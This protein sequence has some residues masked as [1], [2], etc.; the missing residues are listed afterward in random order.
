MRGWKNRRASKHR[1]K[2]SHCHPRTF[3]E[4]LE[5]RVM[6]TGVTLIA[7][8]FGSDASGWVSAMGDAIVERAA[9]SIDFI[10]YTLTVTDPGHD[11]GEL[12]VAASSPQ[13]PALNST[14]AANPEIMLL[15]DWSDVAGGLP[16]GGYHRSTVDV[17]AAVAAKLVTP[18]FLDGLVGHEIVSL[19][20]HLIG[21]SRGGSLVNELARDLGKLGVWV[22]HLSTL[23]PHPVKGISQGDVTNWGDAAMGAPQ[24]VQFA[25]NYWRSD[26]DPLDF[27]GESVAG[28]HNL[29]LSESVLGSFSGYA[30]EHSDVHLW[31]HGTI[32]TRS[33]ARDD[34]NAVPLDWYEDAMGPRQKVG[35]QFSRIRG[36]ARPA[37]GIGI[38]YGGSAQ[39]DNVMVGSPASAWPSIGQVDAPFESSGAM[40]IGTTLDLDYRY[41]LAGG[42]GATVACFADTDRNPFDGNEIQLGSTQSLSVTGSNVSYRL[43]SRPTSS[44]IPGLKYLFLRV[45]A[46]GHTRYDYLPAPLTFANPQVPAPPSNSGFDRVRTL[47]ASGFDVQTFTLGPN[48]HYIIRVADDD[49]DQSSLFASVQ[50]FSPTGASLTGVG[51]G[52]GSWSREAS[53]GSGGTFRLVLSNLINYSLD[54]R[55]LLVRAPGAQS[56]DTDGDGGFLKSGQTR[57][58]TSPT[59]DVDVYRF[60]VSTPKTVVFWSGSTSLAHGAP[61]LSVFGP[62]GTSTGVSASTSSF[63]ASVPGT[64]YMLVDYAHADTSD[65]RPYSVGFQFLPD[66]LS[67]SADGDR[68]TLS[69]GE[70]RTLNLSAEE[71]AV[72]TFAA[73]QN[74]V[75]TVVATGTFVYLDVF[76][77]NGVSLSPT[78]FGLF[79]QADITATAYQS[80]IY[81]VVLRRD[82][83]AAS[84][85]YTVSLSGT[86][87]ALP[88]PTIDY[89][90]EDTGANSSD[91]VTSDNRLLV[92]GSAAPLSTVTLFMQDD[93]VLGTSW[94]GSDGHWVFDYGAVPLP[95]GIAVIGATSF[96]AGTNTASVPSGVRTVTVDTA[97][98]AVNAVDVTSGAGAIAMTFSETGPLT[99]ASDLITLTNLSTNA[100][101]AMISQYAPSTGRLTFTYPAALAQGRYQLRLPSQAVKDL[102]GNLLAAPFIYDFVF[103]GQGQGL[104]LPPGT[105]GGTVLV[106]DLVLDDG[107]TLDLND[108]DLVV[109]NGDFSTL[110]SLVFSGYSSGP[111]STKTGIISTK[112]QHADGLTILALFKNSL[113]GFSDW[114]PGSGN[115]IATGAIV[116][117]YTIM[118]DTNMDGQVTPQDYTAIDSTFGATGLDLGISWFYGDTNFDGNVTRQDYTAI[119]STL[120]MTLGQLPNS[121]AAQGLIADKDRAAQLLIDG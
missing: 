65:S 48:E 119:D 30:T 108:N 5:N 60:T 82:Q 83:F 44:V 120:G 121:F 7:H 115:S 106:D 29:N 18:N 101:V 61:H 45:I 16:L 52:W 77:P 12:D 118:G 41:Q 69:P 57:T 97:S 32:D 96:D 53:S 22:D 88:P 107:G 35:Y 59:I 39:R 102:A 68:G 85:F 9:T 81:Y 111:D 19:P 38:A 42:S 24:N 2:L 36:G 87:N 67:A 31:Y 98:P 117:K 17:A 72:Y 58:G 110:Q 26:A 71:I 28:A 4:P 80:G 92:R 50:L 1:G 105:I 99:I 40:T 43:L 6:L 112:G 46:N 8:G 27:D 104:S 47:P 13:G 56:A 64:Y 94:A 62:S 90:S 55:A 109:N 114:P 100:A 23:D 15:L 103:V 76:G 93:L 37:D 14:S 95:D 3:A 34:G 116:G 20:M 54:Y 66:A 11:G 89:I 91:W 113:A 74:D 25:D 51:L 78:D 75:F 73:R 21:H 70:T 10:R 79:G 33:V 84:P 49:P 86:L 63:F